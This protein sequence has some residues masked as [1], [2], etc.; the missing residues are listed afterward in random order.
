MIEHL[1]DTVTMDPG[2]SR[3]DI[4]NA[5]ISS[6]AHHRKP[7]TM[8]SRIKPMTVPIM[9]IFLQ[10]IVPGEFRGQS[11]ASLLQNLESAAPGDC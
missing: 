11:H 2:L 5:L 10:V 6:P 7:R 1:D 8:T 4:H 9:I 3:L